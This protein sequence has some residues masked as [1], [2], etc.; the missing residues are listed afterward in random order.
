MLAN[1]DDEW[2]GIILFGLYSGQRL[3]DIGRLCWNNIDLKAGLLRFTTGKTK[4][5]MELPLA[6]PI[7]D[8]LLKADTPEAPTAPLFPNA[9]PIAL[10]TT[11]DSRLSQAFRDI[12]VA[13]GLAEA[14]PDD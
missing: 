12:L 8:Y 1:A 13:T 3:K 11:G 10:K 14:H 6:A 9:Y 5:R 4:R 2:K 7:Q